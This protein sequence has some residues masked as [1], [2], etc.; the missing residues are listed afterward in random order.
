MPLEP[1]QNKLIQLYENQELQLASLYQKLAWS[2]PD[3][4]AQFQALASEELEH[5]GWIKHLKISVENG[6][7]VFS[8]GKT[9]TYTITALIAYIKGMIDSLERGEIDLQKA[10]ALVV[11]TE[12][13]LIERQVFAR[14]SGDTGEVERTLRILDDTQRD[15]L[16]RIELFAHQVRTELASHTRSGP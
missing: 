12:K 7:A 11:D 6:S 1:F 16:A 8:E 15:H 13:S 9:R 10:L 2:F 3:Y 4:A 14:F 5:A